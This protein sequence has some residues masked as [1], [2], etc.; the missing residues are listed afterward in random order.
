M[1]AIAQWSATATGVVAAI[2]VALNAGAKITGYGFVIFLFSSIAWTVFGVIEKDWGIV[3]QNAVLTLIN[4]F[5]IYRY[6][7]ADRP[8]NPA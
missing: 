1:N 6:L 7:L 2:M 8:P 4:I 5:G 3:V